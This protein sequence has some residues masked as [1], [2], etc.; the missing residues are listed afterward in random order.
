MYISRTAKKAGFFFFIFDHGT[1][2]SNSFIGVIKGFFKK[3]IFKLYLSEPQNK[4][5]SQ[6]SQRFPDIT[7]TK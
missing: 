3:I 6:I 5:G 2:Q 4:L 1:S 7:W